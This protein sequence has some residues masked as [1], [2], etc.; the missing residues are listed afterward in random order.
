MFGTKV[1]NLQ[2]NVSVND[3]SI[4]GTLKYIEGGLAQTGPLA[5]S[6]YFL[7]LKF[8]TDDWDDYTSVKV[9]LDPSASGMDLVEVK[10][11]PDKN[12]VFKISDKF[13]QTFKI[14]YT[15][16]TTTDTKSFSLRDLVLE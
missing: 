15:N 13:N 5:G 1:K 16:G 6:G 10:T 2:S 3:Y 9:G 8:E 4:T 14:L 7:A 11:D 12:G